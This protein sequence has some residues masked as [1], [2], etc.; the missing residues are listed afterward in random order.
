MSIQTA[1]VYPG[2]GSQVVGM[3]ADLMH[4]RPRMTEV[5]EHVEAVT[6][7]PVIEPMVHGPEDRLRETGTAQLVLF[8]FGVAMTRA[9]T[10]EG[11][12]PQ[13][14]A[15]HSLGEFTALV[16]GGWLDLDE[17]AATVVRRAHAMARCCQ[18]RPGAMA[19][20]LGIDSD[21]VARVLAQHPGRRD[22]GR[23]GTAVIANYNSPRQTVISGDA[24]TVEE[25]REAIRA[26]SIAVSRP[27]PVAGAFHSPL[28][29]PAED[30]L[31]A[32][33][34][35]L[36]LRRGHTPMI[37]S[38]TGELVTDLERYRDVLAHQITAPVHWTRTAR[39]IV[40]HRPSRIVE[41]G[42]GTT[43]RSLIRKVDRGQEIHPC[44]DTTHLRA[45]T[46]TRG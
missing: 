3:G 46:G 7:R 17:A 21:E 11:V 34:A 44:G 9:L 16:A 24:A 27:L 42:P 8:T 26:E 45:L 36:P 30:E 15:G 29:R 2:Q 5:F 38:V 43:L 10:E 35:A 20:V 28:M 19:A 14:V 18:E 32:T 22:D 12:V 13:L 25:I 4:D 37:S 41:V 31:R 40:A 23:P 39:R 6:G 1:F 33:I